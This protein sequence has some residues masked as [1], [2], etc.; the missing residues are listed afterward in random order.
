M[1]DFLKQIETGKKQKP[2][3]VLFY[4][5]HG[6]GKSTWASQ[7]P[8]P[9]YIQ[10]ED[11]LDDLG[12]NRF[13]LAG[14]LNDVMDML[15]ELCGEHKYKT[16][17]IDSLDWLE[18]LI[19]KTVCEEK[20][21]ESIDDIGYAKGYQFALSHW[22]KIKNALNFIRDKKGMHIIL[23]AHSKIEK[24]QSPDVEAY[25]RYTPRL[26]KH[27]TGLLCEW[28]DEVFFANFKTNVV[29]SGEGFNKKS[30]GVGEGR[31]VVYTNERPAYLAKNRLGITENIEMEYS[32]YSA[33][34]NNT[35]KKKGG[36]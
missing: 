19:W 18:R 32:A 29:Q 9:I 33:F 13:P 15:R 4:G 12:V 26:H 36:R 16:L 28:A 10:T 35:P 30:K 24:F 14:H 6:V 23:I 1:T 5:T 20:Q 31:R 2:R 25:D 11:G 17:V 22:E 34:F 21:V 3:R 8:S 27:A 7:A